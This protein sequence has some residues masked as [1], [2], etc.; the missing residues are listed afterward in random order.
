[1]IFLPAIATEVEAGGLVYF[2][3]PGSGLR[4]T[5]IVAA[6]GIAS[7][8]N[9]ME[10]RL[11][12]AWSPELWYRVYAR[13][14]SVFEKSSPTNKRGSPATLAVAYVKQSPMFSA[15]D[16]VLAV[17]QECFEEDGDVF[18]G[19]REHQCSRLRQ[20]LLDHCASVVA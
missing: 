3:R 13:G 9:G 1:V 16:G 8:K 12:I 18:A 20:K 6:S 17:T 7:A 14:R 4:Q 15:R 11:S 5:A 10:R 19:K 2:E